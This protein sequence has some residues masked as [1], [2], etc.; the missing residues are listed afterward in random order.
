MPIIDIGAGGDNMN[1]EQIV[2]NVLQQCINNH[3]N[4]LFLVKRDQYF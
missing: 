4:D 1:V 3:V 2:N